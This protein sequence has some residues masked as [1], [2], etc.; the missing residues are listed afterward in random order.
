MSLLN[1]ID[2]KCEVKTEIVTYEEKKEEELCRF[3]VQRVTQYSSILKENLHKSLTL[4]LGIAVSKI[5]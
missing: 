1:D 4:H 3:C 5:F 2:Y